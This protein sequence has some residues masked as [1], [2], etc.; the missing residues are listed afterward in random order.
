MSCK[1]A[2]NPGANSTTCSTASC[3]P[4]LASPAHNLLPSSSFR[5]LAPTPSHAHPL[6]LQV[7]LPYLREALASHAGA[8][9]VDQV[10]LTHLVQLCSMLV[11]AKVYDLAEWR[12]ALVPYLAPAVGE[13]AAEQVAAAFLA[14][15]VKVGGGLCCWLARAGPDALLGMPH[16]ERAEC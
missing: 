14:R 15:A 9:S 2:L 4:H 6:P 7:L 3:G 5:A 1:K 12:P 13:A 11:N 16:C 10:T 8:K